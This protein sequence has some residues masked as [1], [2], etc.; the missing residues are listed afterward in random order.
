MTVY[1]AGAVCWR[2]DQGRVKV[3]VLHRGQRRDVSL[4]KGKVDPGETLPQTAVR[5]IFEETGLAVH[6]G[7]PLGVSR[8]TLPDGR[9]KVVHYW[10]AEVTDDD[11]NQC[12]F[13]PNDEIA[14][15]EWLSLKK[16]VK[17]L[18]Y[19]RDVEVLRR[20]ENL[21]HEGVLSTFAIIALRHAKAIPASEFDGPDYQRELTPAGLSQAARIVPTLAAFGPEKIISSSAVRCLAT[22]QPF[23]K[24][25]KLPVRATDKISQDAFE[26][27]TS[28]VRQIVSKRVRKRTTAI[29]CAH[30]PVLPELVREVALAA[31][32]R[33]LTRVSRAGDLPVAA[34]S[35]IHL[36]VERPGSGIVAIETHGPR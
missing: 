16:A 19:D 28:D 34:F 11:I 23:A 17:A 35:V 22:V 5:E 31:G 7:A 2:V 30:G 9:D 10:A 24:F 6:L 15:M 36:S 27:G 18:T 33:N 20:F 3:L 25:A 8:Y 1:A 29:L 12:R 32:G 4:P 13:V 21:I 26:A 14:G